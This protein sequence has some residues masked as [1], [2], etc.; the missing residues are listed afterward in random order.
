MSRAR[1]VFLSAGVTCHIC[2]MRG[3]YGV[4]LSFFR[5]TCGLL[6]TVAS[7]FSVDEE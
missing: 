7:G 3:G 5:V 4:Q 1:A 6:V 2:E